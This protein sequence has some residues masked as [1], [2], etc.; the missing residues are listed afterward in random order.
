M[1]TFNHII[2]SVF[3]ANIETGP[4]KGIGPFGFE[5]EAVS[6]ATT[7]TQFGN[8][9]STVITVITVVGGLAFIIYFTMGGLK[10]ITAGGDK[11]KI[12][13]AQTQMTQGIVGLVVI[14]VGLFVVGIIGGILG[15]DFLNPFNTLS[16]IWTP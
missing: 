12:Q 1:L 2:K 6:E 5:N 16:K 15:I 4:I 11:T 13:E 3:A 9:L 10:W 14:T 7:K 8:I